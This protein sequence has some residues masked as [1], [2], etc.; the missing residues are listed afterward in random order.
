MYNVHLC[1]C[2]SVWV[3]SRLYTLLCSIKHNII[4]SACTNQVRTHTVSENIY[5]PLMN[6]SLITV[7]VSIKYMHNNIIR[8]TNDDN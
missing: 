5:L 4:E 2:T 7:T 8:P 3:F 6:V 1:V